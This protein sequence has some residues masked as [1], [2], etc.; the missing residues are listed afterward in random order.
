M[1]NLIK[2]K[3]KLKIRS[4][5]RYKND[6]FSS[7]TTKDPTTTTILTTVSGILRIIK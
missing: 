1:K 3:S 5:Y 6:T 7:E 2:Y 4:I